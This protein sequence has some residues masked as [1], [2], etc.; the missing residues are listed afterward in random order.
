MAAIHSI[1]SFF[2]KLPIRRYLGV[3]LLYFVLLYALKLITAKP[4]YL[5]NWPHLFMLFGGLVGMGIGLVDRL[6]YAYVSKPEEEY[7]QKIR[8]YVKQLQFVN[9]L[10]YIVTHE[11]PKR[12]LSTTSIF[13]LGAWIV[14]ALL[15]IT[16]SYNGFSRGLI[17][18][19]GLLLAY[20]LFTDW[21]QPQRLKE[22]LFWP[23]ARKMTDQELKI[24]VYTYLGAFLLLSLLAV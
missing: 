3:Y 9:L 4:T 5:F 12:H 10:D 7:S 19:I 23:V 16:S 24:S 8:S 22:R 18:G 13:F 14:L 17:L 21:K 2:K 15:L 20:E 6:V 1:G 11:D